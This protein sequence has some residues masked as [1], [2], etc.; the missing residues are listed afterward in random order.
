MPS[1]REWFSYFDF[2]RGFFDEALGATAA[3]PPDARLDEIKRAVEEV[4]ALRKF[5][6]VTVDMIFS[7]GELGFQEF[8]T[9]GLR[10]GAPARERLRG[11]DGDVDAHGVDGALGIGPP[12][13]CLWKR[14][15]RHPQSRPGVIYHDPIFEGAPGNSVHMVNGQSGHDVTA[16][17]VPKKIMERA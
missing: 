2:C 9:C 14:H 11:R 17:L 7:F 13:D 15:R 3:E 5:T 12:G 6:Q 8:E 1:I 16:A 4:E 10:H